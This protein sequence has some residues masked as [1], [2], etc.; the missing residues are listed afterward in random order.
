MAEINDTYANR[1][2]QKEYVVTGLTED[3]VILDG[4]KQVTDRGLATNFIYM[5]KRSAAPAPVKQ[6]RKRRNFKKPIFI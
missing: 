1:V 3:G 5:G 6:K 2:N 4:T